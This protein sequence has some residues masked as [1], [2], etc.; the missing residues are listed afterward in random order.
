MNTIIGSITGVVSII[1]LFNYKILYKLVCHIS[2]NQTLLF[3]NS[4]LWQTRISSKVYAVAREILMESHILW[5]YCKA[6]GTARLQE[7]SVGQ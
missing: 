6:L 3:Y 2:T 7:W 4:K 5:R 1:T